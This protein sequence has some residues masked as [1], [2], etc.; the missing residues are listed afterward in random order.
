SAYLATI[1]IIPNILPVV[2]VLGALGWLNIPLDLMTIMI[3]AVT[4]GIAV[5]FAIHYI[6]RFQY[7]FPED[8]DYIATMYRCHNTIGRAMWYTSITIIV[9]FSIL[10]LSNFIPTIYFGI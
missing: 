10:V 8:R 4:F 1:A 7:E 9:G 6:T 3:A 2:L 5:D